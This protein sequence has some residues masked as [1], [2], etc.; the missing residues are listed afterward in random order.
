[1]KKHAISFTSDLTGLNHEA[2]TERLLEIGSALGSAEMLGKDHLAVHLEAGPNLIV[3]FEQGNIL[4]RTAKDAEPTGFAYTRRDGWSSLSILTT[5]MNW[6]R[7]EAIFEY[8]DR[9]V[10][11]GFFDGFERVLFFGE[12]IG[13]YGACAYSVAAPGSTVLALSPISTLTPS[14]AR[15]DPRAG[16]AS[17]VDFTSRYGFAPSMV[18]AAEEAFVVYCPQH[19]HESQHAAIFVRDNVTFLPAFHSTKSIGERLEELDILEDLIRAAM[20][21]SLTRC[22]FADQYRERREDP[23]Y[24]HA[25]IQRACDVGHL[26]LAIKASERAQQL[27]DDDDL[28]V[29]LDALLAQRDLEKTKA[30]SV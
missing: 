8:I 22:I 1:M 15:F 14:I 26:E 10:D 30:S 23:K 6:F 25:L 24:L 19:R 3:T 13:G 2:W 4:R 18:E 12:Q 27:L 7:D 20:A 16:R 17:R 29:Q 28:K 11:D 21:G 5:R 9:L